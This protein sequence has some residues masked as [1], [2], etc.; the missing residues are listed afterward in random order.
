LAHGNLAVTTPLVDTLLG[1]ALIAVIP[2]AFGLDRLTARLRGAAVVAGCLATTGLALRRDVALA[3]TLGTPWLVLTLVAA[4]LAIRRWWRAERTWAVIGRP[5]AFAYLAFGAAWLVLELADARPL[6]LTPPFIE[7]AAVHFSYAGFTA[8][9]LATVAAR[10]VATSSPAQATV[11]VTLV[12]VGPPVVAVGFRF[13]PPVQVVGAVLLTTGLSML[14]W[15]TARIVIPAAGDR[16]AATML[17]ASSVAVVVPM[18]LAVW[19]AIGMTAALPAPSVPT[20]ART[21]G[22]TNAV[23]FAFLGVLGWRR[24]QREELGERTTRTEQASAALKPACQTCTATRP[25]R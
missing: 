22:L 8:G 19:W 16:L 12:L 21:H 18:L 1:F 9:M 13:A 10:R 24:L 5:V 6:G 3:V 4:L 15:L 2:L 17:G 11:M 14:S 7:L 23:G 25:K 20:M